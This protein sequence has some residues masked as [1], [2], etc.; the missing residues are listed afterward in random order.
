M[1]ARQHFILSLI[2]PPLLAGAAC[3]GMYLMNFWFEMNPPVLMISY[4]VTALIFSQVG[5]WMVRTFVS[6]R[7]PYC[8]GKTYEIQGRP[9]R[10]MC[11]VCGRDH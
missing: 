1:N 9:N 3:Y 5:R 7:C 6:V 8:K 2:V 10:F 11:L 4:L